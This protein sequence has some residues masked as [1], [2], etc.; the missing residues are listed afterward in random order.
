MYE[1]KCTFRGGEGGGRDLVRKPPALPYSRDLKVSD[2]PR[3]MTRRDPLRKLRGR[4][5]PKQSTKQPPNNPITPPGECGGGV[6]SSVLP[7][8]SVRGAPG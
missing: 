8:P 5:I 1:A 7:D 6:R 3:N 2:T 4:R